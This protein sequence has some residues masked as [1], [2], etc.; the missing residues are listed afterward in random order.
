MDELNVWEVKM[1]LKLALIQMDIRWHDRGSN[2][3]KAGDL[4]SQAVDRGA[5]I[6]VLPEMFSTGFSMETNMLF[7]YLNV[8]NCFEISLPKQ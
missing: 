1:S 8:F 4:I 3:L 5:D 6:V 2:H 7:S